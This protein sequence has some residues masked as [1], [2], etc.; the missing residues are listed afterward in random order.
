MKRH[1][2]FIFIF[3][4]IIGKISPGQSALETITNKLKG[5]DKG[6]KNVLNK[7]YPLNSTSNER[8]N[9]GKS[10]EVIKLDI[11]EGTNKLW[12]KITILDIKSNYQFTEQETFFNSVF[13]KKESIKPPYIPTTSIMDFYIFNSSGDAESFKKNEIYF[14]CFQK[15]KTFSF[16]DSINVKDNNY[17]IGLRNP[18]TFDGIKVILEVVSEGFY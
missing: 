1:I 13:E 2:L 12:F 4:L 17:W 16:Y 15:L 3:S 7:T 10:K 9:K 14:N 18:N 8:F 6:Y 11:P 5:K